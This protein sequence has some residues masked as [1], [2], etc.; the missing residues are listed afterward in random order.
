MT[1]ALL[2]TLIGAAGLAVGA[3]MIYP[4]AGVIVASLAA[5]LVGTFII[6]QGGDS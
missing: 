4:P 5:I 1:L 3:A 6:D 2:V